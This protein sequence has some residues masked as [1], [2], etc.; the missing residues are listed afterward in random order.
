MK[1]RP[2]KKILKVK[3]IAKDG[4]EEAE[5]KLYGSWLRKNGFEQINSRF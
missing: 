1:M 5:L 4:N 3:P 2:Y